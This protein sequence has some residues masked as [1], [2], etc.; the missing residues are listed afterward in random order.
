MEQNSLLTSL[1]PLL[2]L[3]AIFYFLVI[4]PQQ[5]QAKAHKQMISEL[6]KGDKIITNG[7]LICEVIKPEDDFIKVKLND[8]NTIA[9]ISKEFIAKKID[10]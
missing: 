3:F 1:L 10:V 7:G 5:K 4:R 6:T 8:E 9:K 2:V